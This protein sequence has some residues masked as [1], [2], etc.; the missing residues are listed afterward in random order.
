MGEGDKE[1][2]GAEKK[3]ETDK[4]E[5]AVEGKK[6]DAA[7]KKE[8]AA[9]DKK[10]ETAEDEDEDKKKTQTK[11]TITL[12]V[13]RAQK[14][15]ERKKE[16]TEKFE[17]IKIDRLNRYQGVNLYVKNLDER[18]DD[19]LLRKEFSQFGSIT[20]ARV[21]RDPVD[22]N[23][24]VP[25][26]DSQGRVV[27]HSKGFGFV[28]FSTPEEATKS[29]T[30]M[31]GKM[32]MGKPIYVALAQRKDARRAQLE[33]QHQQRAVGRGIPMQPQMYPA[34]PMYFAQG[35]MQ[36]GM[37][38]QARQ[39]FAYLPPQMMPRGMMQQPRGMP[40]T[41]GYPMQPGYA[42]QMMNQGSQG[43]GGRGGNRRGRQPGRNMPRG[44]ANMNQ[45]L[46][47]MTPPQ[48][49]P[50][51]IMPQ[52]A[53]PGQPP[54]LTAAAL[55]NASD[56]EQKNMIG[57]RLYPLIQQQVAPESA[58]KITGMLLE[59][60]NPELL[61]LLE[62]PDALNAKVAEAINVLQQHGNRGGI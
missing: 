23:K 8:E 44:M 28:C 11:T 40:F 34:A 3:E 13:C 38:P 55:A 52:Q 7:E 22:N 31:N 54:A 29:V 5:E 24:G 60:D 1:S 56:N 14:K 16:L 9:E 53:Q 19:D 36:G 48:Q 17:K 45:Q 37:P 39:N 61:H 6:D 46:P 15:S 62:S 20:S 35:G 26:K 51:N 21:M 41:R 42:P 18:V 4:K 25:E 30:E 58:G 57:E 32:V 50:Q 49:Q 43:L 47:Q 27:G 59:M 10:E 2:K 33:A 12:Y